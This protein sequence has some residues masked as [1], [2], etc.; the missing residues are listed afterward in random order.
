MI[1]E[2]DVIEERSVSLVEVAEILNQIETPTVEQK[3]AFKH[4]K[5]SSKLKKEDALSLRKDLED[6]DLRKLKDQHVSKII[7]FLPEDIDDLKLILEDSLTAFTN[8]ELQK[9]LD[10]IA[11]YK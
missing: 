5:S 11:K 7:D 1:T 10:I 3:K 2:F 9:V 8:E 6:V 4:A